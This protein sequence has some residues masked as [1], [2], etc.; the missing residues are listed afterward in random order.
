[1]SSS[2]A[3]AIRGYCTSSRINCD[4]AKSLAQDQ[5]CDGLLASDLA[6][7][8]LILQQVQ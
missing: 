8:Q 5:A 3:V 7:S 4:M 6:M 1:M 2:T